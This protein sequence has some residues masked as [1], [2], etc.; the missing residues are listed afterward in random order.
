M[1]TTTRARWTALDELTLRVGIHD[2]LPLATIAGQLGR[3]PTA[4]REK[5]KRLGLRRG[6]RHTPS[7]AAVAHVMGV[8]CPKTVTSWVGRG[9]LRPIGGRRVRPWRFDSTALWDLVALPAAVVAIQPER[10]TDAEL[11]A[12]AL[13]QRAHLPRWLPL[14]AVATRYHVT[15]GTVAGWVAQGRFAAEHLQRYGVLW[16]RA[17][18]LDGFVPPCQRPRVRYAC[19][20]RRLPTGAARPPANHVLI[21]AACWPDV[22]VLPGG[23]LLRLVPPGQ[24]GVPSAEASIIDDRRRAA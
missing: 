6:D 24:G 8:G 3:T 1:M 10:I 5:R 17:D 15:S 20:G 16:L 14:R 18:A 11:H 22:R 7:A 4:V 13:E 2:G 9:W 23:H 21:C 12:Y 19:C